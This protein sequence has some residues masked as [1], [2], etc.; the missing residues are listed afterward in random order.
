MAEFCL[1]CMNRLGGTQLTE[2]DVVLLD[3]LCE[4]CGRVVP[5]VVRYRSP[6]E[7]M[8]LISNKVL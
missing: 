2:A 5:C 1:A 3:D 8:I 7:K 6:P 4:G